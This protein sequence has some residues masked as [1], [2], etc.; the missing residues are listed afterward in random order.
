MSW[1]P[2]PPKSRL[3]GDAFTLFTLHLCCFPTHWQLGD[4]GAGKQ[5]DSFFPRHQVHPRGGIAA[6][7]NPRGNLP[8]ISGNFT[9]DE[10]VF[11]MF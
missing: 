6:P 2:I 8:S 9:G 11:P 1:G 4:E 3:L 10:M 5:L 7:L